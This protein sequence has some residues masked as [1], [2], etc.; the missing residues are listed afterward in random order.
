MRMRRGAKRRP[1]TQKSERSAAPSVKALAE[2]LVDV[3]VARME[4]DLA[5]RAAPARLLTLGQAADLLQVRPATVRGLIRA[6]G[7]VATRFGRLV[8][9]HPEDLAEFQRRRRVLKA[10]DG[11]T[12]AVDAL[13]GKSAPDLEALPAAPKRVKAC[14]GDSYVSGQGGRQ[15]EGEPHA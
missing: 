13:A 11:L 8:R 14:G 12:L 4:R 7:L 15:G 2:E 3:A 10:G 5:G 6:G 9:V 1:T